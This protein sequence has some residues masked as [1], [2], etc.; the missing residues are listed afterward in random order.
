MARY[1]TLPAIFGLRDWFEQRFGELCREHDERYVARDVT[2]WE[3]D[4]SLFRGMVR[5]GKRYL[6][7]AVAAW[8]FCWSPIGLWYWYTD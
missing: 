4:A 7:I 2:K 5:R 3:A 6:P 1:C 8:V